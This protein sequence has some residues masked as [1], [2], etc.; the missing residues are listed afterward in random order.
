MTTIA[1]RVS[2]GESY[3]YPPSFLDRFM[4]FV[5]R[6]PIPY[7]LTYL[8][9]FLVQSTLMHLL[10]WADGWVPAYRI[11]PILFLFPAWQW[12]TLAIMTYVDSVSVQALSIFAPL[13]G[14]DEAE[15][16]R[17]EYEFSTMPARGVILSGL[18]WGIVYGIQIYV[19]FDGFFVAYGMGTL[20]TAVLILEGL[21]TFMTGGAIY[22]YSFR[23]LLLVN[24]TV[25]GVRKFNLFR[26]DPVYEFARVTA[27]VGVSWMI[28]LALTLL[29]LP[30]PIVEGLTLVILVLQVILAVAA[31]VLPLWFVHR[32]LETE[33]LRLLAEFHRHVELATGRLH[34]SLEEDDMGP[35][36]QLKDAMLG[37]SA[38]RDIL[39]AL[40]TWPWRPG[41]LAGFLSA[42][43]LPILLFVLQLGI[44]KLLGK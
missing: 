43:V 31:F 5:E 37:L 7:W 6:L 12:L 28:M 4:N 3:P 40:P 18:L 8:L 21:I 32:R 24:R 22:Y 2:A 16:K 42:T 15:R 41:T 9:L 34:R 33:K 25:K 39:N 23:Q 26:L 35:V 1:K 13:L 14:I 38:E 19:F 10:A 11:S 27:L 29:L 17:L 20:F 36:T 44:G 30:A